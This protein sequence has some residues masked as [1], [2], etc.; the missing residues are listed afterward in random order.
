MG[1]RR[2]L[3]PKAFVHEAFVRKKRS[4]VVTIPQIL[5]GLSWVFHSQFG[6]VRMRHNEIVDCGV[7]FGYGERWCTKGRYWTATY[8]HDLASGTAEG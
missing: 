6:D 5:K 2:A 1:S 7:E 4:K 3:S 8:I